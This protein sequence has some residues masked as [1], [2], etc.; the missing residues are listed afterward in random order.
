MTYDEF[1]KRLSKATCK[2]QLLCEEDW[3]IVQLVYT[4]HPAIS[5][6]EG[7]DEI[8]ELYCAMGMPF[9]RSM[10][11]QALTCRLLEEALNRA[12]TELAKREESLQESIKRV[13][14][15]RDADIAQI[16]QRCKYEIEDIRAGFTEGAAEL[17]VRIQELTDRLGSLEG[18]ETK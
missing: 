4:W 18:G 10:A 8:V 14:Q 9:I 13:E 16:S 11:P 12:K 17:I 5:N 3:D 2:P 1:I 6:T 7:K 15:L